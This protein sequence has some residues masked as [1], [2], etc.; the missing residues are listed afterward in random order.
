MPTFHALVGSIP[1]LADAILETWR[2]TIDRLGLPT[3]RRAANELGVEELYLRARAN[4]RV[5]NL[6][7]AARQFAAVTKMM[8]TFADAFEEY[9]EALDREGRTE[10]ARRNY[11]VARKLRQEAKPGTADRCFVL[12]RRRVFASDIVA[13]TAVLRSGSSK[14]RAL[15]YLARGNAYLASGR[16]KLALLDYGFVLQLAPNPEVV[17]LKA[18]ALT[19]LGRYRQA[20]TAFDIAIAGR[21]QDG[22]IYG[23]RAIARLALDRLD[24]ADADWRRQLEL[25]PQERS[26]A[27]ACVLLRLADHELAVPELR[28]AIEKEPAEPYWRLYH[29]AALRR[30]GT[31]A[32]AL[33][34]GPSPTGSWPAPLLALHAGRMSAD[35]ALKQA[36]TA[37]RRAEAMFQIGVAAYGHDRAEA[38]RWWAKVID[39]AGPATIEH[40]AARHEL[41]RFSS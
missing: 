25:L 12:R 34:T 11:D 16:A 14:Q 3:R 1:S 2:G 22:E 13:Y 32:G 18:E 17:A 8:P 27:R 19:M 28:C 23:G 39:T 5:G 21:P 4:A 35:D 37:E 6:D 7:V 9:G 15:T 30:L 40:A 20:L 26:A 38:R 10:L 36:D 24:D 33:D 41:T 29:G 31:T